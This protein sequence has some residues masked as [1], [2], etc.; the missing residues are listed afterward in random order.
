M[1][2]RLRE[3]GI[4][5]LVQLDVRLLPDIIARKGND[6]LLITDDVCGQLWGT[7]E[8]TLIRFF[9]LTMCQCF[10]NVRDYRLCMTMLVHIP[11]YSDKTYNKTMYPCYN[12]LRDL[13][14]AIQ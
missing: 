9:D 5:C 7:N 11:L 13:P 8:V 10:V 2:N 6:R 12:G 3:R 4:H 14:I 1:R